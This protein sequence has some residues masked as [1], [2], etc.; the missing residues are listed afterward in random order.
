MFNLTKQ[1]DGQIAGAAMS[2]ERNHR[3]DE[4]EELCAVRADHLITHWVID[5]IGFD[6]ATFCFQADAVENAVLNRV[7]ET[8]GFLDLW[9]GIEQRVER[10]ESLEDVRVVEPIDVLKDD[11]V[12]F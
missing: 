8:Y 12:S 4:I 9:R 3:N 1:F 10:T 11:D 2:N 7:D 5:C 6:V